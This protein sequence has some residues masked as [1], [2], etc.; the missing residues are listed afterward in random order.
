MKIITTNKNAK[1]DYEILETFEAGMSL[2]G[3]EVKS[4]RASEVALTNSF[5]SIYKNELWLKESFFKQYMQV[6]CNE[7]QDRK[8]LM[9]K[10]EILS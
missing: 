10:N 3:W 8:L 7:T 2:D 9:H 6:K 1:R 4:A 5:C